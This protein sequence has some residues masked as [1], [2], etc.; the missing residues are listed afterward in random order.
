M[1]V[2]IID[3]EDLSLEELFLKKKQHLFRRPL[4]AF[5]VEPKRWEDLGKSLIYIFC[6]PGHEC[7]RVKK[8]LKYSFSILKKEIINFENFSREILKLKKLRPK[9]RRAWIAYFYPSGT[10]HLNVQFYELLQK[11]SIELS[12]SLDHQLIIRLPFDKMRR[13]RLNP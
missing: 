12:K 7:I 1:K 8:S 5:P 9:R 2:E 6:P 4:V 3:L 13:K 10:G 11:D